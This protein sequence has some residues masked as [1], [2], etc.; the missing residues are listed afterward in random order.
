MQG[1]R[2]ERAD[3]KGPAVRSAGVLRLLYLLVPR[4]QLQ[5]R[6]GLGEDA[7]KVAKL[8]FSENLKAAMEFAL[9]TARR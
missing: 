6:L 8:R 3:R 7:Q 5:K 9:R 1:R 4:A 2:H